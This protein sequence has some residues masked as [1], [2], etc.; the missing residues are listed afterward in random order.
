MKLFIVTEDKLWTT[1]MSKKETWSFLHSC[2]YKA[3]RIR[4]YKGWEEEEEEE[5]RG[6]QLTDHEKRC[7]LEQ[8]NPSLPWRFRFETAHAPRLALCRRME[9]LLKQITCNLITSKIDKMGSIIWLGCVLCLVKDSKSD[10]N[11][12]S[13][14]LFFYLYCIYEERKKLALL[15]FQTHVPKI[16]QRRHEWFRNPEIKLNNL[17]WESPLA[18][19][20]VHHTFPCRAVSNLKLCTA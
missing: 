9:T 15:F 5:E 14:N 17:F 10:T 20:H 12:H 1:Q 13:I 6:M 18:C 11:I 16:N 4:I 3:Y 7:S 8:I 2:M 19:H